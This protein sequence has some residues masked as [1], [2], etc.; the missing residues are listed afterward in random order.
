LK[1][2]TII[3]DWNG[4]LLNDA[5]LCRDVMNQILKHRGLPL[6]SAIKYQ[7]VFD[8]PVR[9]YY[10][11]LGFN[12]ANESFESLGTEFINQ[13]EIRRDECKL[14]PG[15]RSLISH[16]KSIKVKQ[17]ILSA[18]RNETLISLL[19]NKGLDSSFDWIVGADDHYAHGKHEQG[20]KLMLDIRGNRHDT[21]L[22]G[23]TLHDHE[24]A[25][26]MGINC[27]L[28][29]A[30]HQSKER[31]LKSGKP[32]LNNLAEVREWLEERI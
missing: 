5:F 28:V 22:I 15:A 30:G 27:L 18:Y 31:L 7:D 8:F 1:L 25:E 6:L 26:S 19:K 10:A 2:K 17:A 3:W 4:T 24:V 9:A 14:Q 23:D 11:K 16:L 13:Y 21:I 12:Y 32:V 20:A 29:H